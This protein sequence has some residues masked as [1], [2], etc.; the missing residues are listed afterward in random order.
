MQVA[1]DAF[2]VD[3]SDRLALSQEVRLTPAEVR[4][5]LSEGLLEA[6]FATTTQG[7][8][9]RLR[10]VLPLCP[11]RV[12]LGFVGL[13]GYAVAMPIFF[14]KSASAS[15]PAPGEGVDRALS[16]SSSMVPPTSASWS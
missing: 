15:A 7:V 9:V 2:H 10:R 11:P 13:Y 12:S 8:A 3:V 6:R 1:V 16:M 5:L 14:F 4:V